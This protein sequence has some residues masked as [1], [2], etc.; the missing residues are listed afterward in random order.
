MKLIGKNSN[1]ND[2]NHISVDAGLNAWIGQLA[3]GT[4]T[5]VQTMPWDYEP[6][7]CGSGW[8]G[9]CNQGWIQ[10][11]ICEDDLTNKAYFN[12]VYNEAIELTAYLCKK[13]GIDPK[14]KVSHCGTQVPTILCH[15]DSYELGLGSGHSDVYHWFKKY[16]KNMTDVRND[17]AAAMK[18]D[19]KKFVK[20]VMVGY[21]K[22]KTKAY[23]TNKTTS[24]VVK[25]LPKATK[26]DI[27]RE[28]NE[29]YDVVIGEQHVYVEK[30]NVSKTK[31]EIFTPENF[32]GYSKVDGLNIRKSNSTNSEILSTINKGKAVKVIAVGSKDWY[33]INY[34]DGKAFVYK[35]YITKKKPEEKKETNK[36]YKV[37]VT[38][39]AGLNVREKASTSSKVKAALPYNTTVT[40][41]KT[42]GG[43]GYVES[44][45]GWIYLTYTKKV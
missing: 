33:K 14:G 18:E 11:E 27:V 19:G 43:W 6:W 1:G 8:R 30:F 9:S 32:T 15:W 35:E 44:K 4:V 12:K 34:K 29:W 38:A 36:S 24:K 21:T 2:W 7:G 37:K 5:T 39:K 16:N 26:I 17:V 45:K 28:N 23:E 25:E 13:F 10:F 40:I 41:S 3:D 31:P 20:N 42:S 22:T